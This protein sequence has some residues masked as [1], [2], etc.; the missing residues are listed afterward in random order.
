MASVHFLTDASPLRMADAVAA[1]IVAP[2]GRYLLQLRDDIPKIF[3]PG[4][5]GCF[6]GAVNDG[7]DPVEAL[8]RELYEEIEMT[9][10]VFRKFVGLD[11][12]LVPIGKQKYCRDFFE[13]NTT[14]E[15]I[16]RLVLHEGAAM[17]LFTPSEL[18]ALPNI[19]PYDS[20]ALWLHSARDRLI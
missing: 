9:V 3:Y 16:E 7:E 11:F 19:T 1:L 5:W 18:H 13:V 12:D 17:K 15:E 6:G 20:F 2:D 4:Y 8:K 10:Q 14:E